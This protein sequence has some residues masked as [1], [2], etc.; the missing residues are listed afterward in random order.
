MAS[1]GGTKTPPVE[2]GLAS[3]TKRPLQEGRQKA[4]ERE[5][6]D[7]DPD[8]ARVAASEGMRA[9]SERVRARE[10]VAAAVS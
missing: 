8:N 4:L 3:A 2:G 7:P 5:G 10:E 1:E 6:R 9:L